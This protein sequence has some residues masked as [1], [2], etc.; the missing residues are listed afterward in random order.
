M[1]PG[2]QDLASNS[3]VIPGASKSIGRATAINLATGRC[4]ALGTC[5][6]TKSLHLIDSITDEVAGLYHSDGRPNETPK[7]VGIVAN[8]FASDC[9]NTIAD[10][11]D[12]HFGD[13]YIVVL[14][15]G[16][17]GG[18]GGG[19]Q[20]PVMTV[21]EVVKRKL[22]RNDSCIV[23]TSSGR[24]TKPNPAAYVSTRTLNAIEQ[25]SR[26]TYSIR[27]MYCATKAALG[28]YV[29]CWTDTF[30]GKHPRFDFMAD[31]TANSMQVELRRRRPRRD[32][33][34]RRW[35]STSK[36]LRR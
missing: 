33:G 7:M 36:S 8:I 20:T 29:R 31:T 16:A 32:T 13:V 12:E 27:P 17:R 4:S 34:P 11:V 6:T 9:H 2:E 26:P 23:H 15:A 1:Y 19:I 28:S 22:F 24:S 14:N 35:T 30:G 5:S 25:P 10:A 3:A 18:G 21:D